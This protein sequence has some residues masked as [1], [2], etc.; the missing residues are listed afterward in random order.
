MIVPVHG[1]TALHLA[2]QAGENRIVRIL[3]EGGNA[4]IEAKARITWPHLST[5]HVIITPLHYAASRGL[6]E[7]CELLL[8]LGADVNS[9]PKRRK[10]GGG[11]EEQFSPLHLACYSG[12]AQVVSLLIE[13]GAS[14]TCVTRRTSVTYMNCLDLAVYANQTENALAVI[15][16]NRWREALMNETIFHGTAETTIMAKLVKVMPVVAREVLDNCL[17]SSP[18]EQPREQGREEPGLETTSDH[19]QDKEAFDNL[20]H[21][22]MPVF[23]RLTLHQVPGS[24]RKENEEEF[25]FNDEFISDEE[26]RNALIKDRYARIVSGKFTIDRMLVV[27]KGDCLRQMIRHNR[28]E[29]LSHPLVRVLLLLK[30][31][32]FGRAAFF[33][34]LLSYVVFL[35]FVNG[36]VLSTAFMAPH[37]YKD[38]HILQDLNGTDCERIRHHT[39]TVGPE[40]LISTFGQVC[41]IGIWIL[42]ISLLLKEVIQI[43]FSGLAGYLSGIENYIE[44]FVYLTAILLVVDFEQCQTETGL[45]LDWQWQLGALSVFWSWINLL[46]FIRRLPVFGLYVVMFTTI[47]RSFLLF[48]PVLLLFIVAF[49]ISFHCLLANQVSF[50][51]EITSIIKTFV[52]MVGEM[53][54]GNMFDDRASEQQRGVMIWYEAVTYVQFALFLVVMAILVMNLLVG[55]AVDD[56]Q[57]VMKQSQQQMLA[58]QA[59]FLLD[60]EQVIDEVLLFLKRHSGGFLAKDGRGKGM[61]EVGRGDDSTKCTYQDIVQRGPKR[62]RICL[63][64]IT[65]PMARIARNW[66]MSETAII[67]EWYNSRQATHGKTDE[68]M[69]RIPEQ[70]ESLA[71][72]HK[73][74]QEGLVTVKE[75]SKISARDIKEQM[76]RDMNEVKENINAEFSKMTGEMNKISKMLETFSKT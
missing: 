27:R 68:D 51:Y 7:T 12:N 39:A 48:L 55:L 9:Q 33:M 6:L 67:E 28:V 17:E 10:P 26:W 24:N 35:F 71:R 14:V 1:F 23:D 58:L 52:M 37:Q 75:E 22:G 47:L 38:L 57:E 69:S 15:R 62:N 41:R 5:S 11:C 40:A 53:D 74:L 46:L 76:K 36:Y 25:A 19:K 4:N 44:W 43:P 63:R 16:S 50:R 30:W 70:I 13:R 32:R 29:L 34:N 61:A 42:G 21:S 73:E 54:Y 72:K 18:K 31:R 59:K 2:A 45:R 20:E 66:V 60:C 65:G 64:R 3:V 49:A 56:I 8:D